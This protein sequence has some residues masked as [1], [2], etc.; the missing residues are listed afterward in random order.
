MRTLECKRG[1]H[2]VCPS[3]QCQCRCHYPGPEQGDE[4]HYDGE[5]RDVTEEAEEAAIKS[6]YGVGGVE[7]KVV[8]GRIWVRFIVPQ[9]Y[10]EITIKKADYYDYP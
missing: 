6:A 5:A 9:E 1:N 7:V 2:K 8:D 4:P 3:C 10:I